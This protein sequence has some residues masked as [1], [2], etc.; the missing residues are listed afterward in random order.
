[1]AARRTRPARASDTPLVAADA[2]QVPEADP[3]Q[4]ARILILRRL[5]SAPRTRA[6]LERFLDQRGV[7]DDAAMRVLD[8]YEEVG[9]VDD[10][11]FAQGWVRSRHGSRGLGRRAVATEL[12]R[13]G[14]PDHI[15][16]DALEPIDEATERARAMTLAR[17]RWPQVAGLPYQT[18]V[19]RLLGT[20]TR[21]GYDISMAS[22]VVRAVVDDESSNI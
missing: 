2:S 5:E 14:V 21:R 22:Q 4:V 1:M 16:E 20:L 9:L 18:Q 11:T 6:E 15:I 17:A 12:R 13:K 8:R 7:P 10:A 3:D 19:R